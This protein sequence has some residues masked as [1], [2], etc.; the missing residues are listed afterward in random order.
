[1]NLWYYIRLG[2]RIIFEN[3]FDNIDN[4]KKKKKKM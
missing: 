4:Y 2:S 3:D 1:M